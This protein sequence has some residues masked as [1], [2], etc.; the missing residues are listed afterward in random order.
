MLYVF[1]YMSLKK[2]EQISNI[3]HCLKKNW[4]LDKVLSLDSDLYDEYG[5]I[6]SS[7]VRVINHMVLEKRLWAK[8]KNK[9]INT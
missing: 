4:A 3:L 6:L 7:L 1:I 9:F 2:T 5:I 8:M